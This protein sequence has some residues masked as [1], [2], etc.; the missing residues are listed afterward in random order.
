MVRLIMLG[1]LIQA[2]TSSI[3][4]SPIDLTIKVLSQ[5]SYCIEHFT[6]VYGFWSFY[7]HFRG[8]KEDIDIDNIL[9]PWCTWVRCCAITTFAI[10]SLLHMLASMV[11]PSLLSAWEKQLVL[12]YS[13]NGPVGRTYV[14]LAFIE[15]AYNFLTRTGMLVV[16]WMVIKAWKELLKPFNQPKRMELSKMASSD[17]IQKEFTKLIG[18]YTK[19]G[20]LVA[21]LQEIFQGWFVIKWIVYFIDIT[22]HSLLAAKIIFKHAGV[23]E[24][25]ELASVFAHLIYDI[26]AFGLLYFC[27]AM[28]NLYHA[29]YRRQHD[30]KQRELLSHSS[31]GSLWIMQSMNVIPENPEYNFVPS[32][33]LIDFPLNSPGYTLTML[34]T[35]FAFV[36]NFLTQYDY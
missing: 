27:G 22:G 18:G 8:K 4:D 29:K 19:T 17:N 15:H 12:S 21:A 2:S 6:L 33:C 31:T 23:K 24:N 26:L 7:Y 14:A 3:K 30:L 11:P 1:I 16:T 34:L 9:K 10:F 32:V 13:S 20:Q 35:L 28:M 36:A 5:T 25:S